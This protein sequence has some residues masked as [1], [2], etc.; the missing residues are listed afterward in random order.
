MVGVTGAV[1]YLAGL[2]GAASGSRRER[3]V[4]SYDALEQHERGLL[5]RLLAGLDEID[6]VTLHGQPARRTPTVLFDVDGTPAA[7]VHRALAR[8][9]VNAPA[10]SF[11]A[12]EASRWFGL[13]DS[14]AVRAG[15]APY[16][17]EQD[18]D[19]LLDAVRGIAMPHCRG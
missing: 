3:L 12:L 15:I 11:Y 4:A 16:T 6:G 8:Q 19:R 7:Q 17:N 10:G 14:G 2:D 18:V 13:G 5:N 1:D 9:G